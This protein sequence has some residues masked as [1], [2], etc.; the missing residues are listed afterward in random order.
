MSTTDVLR[1]TVNATRAHHVLAELNAA[2][3]W[4]LLTEKINLMEIDEA[5]LH[6]AMNERFSGGEKRRHETLQMAVRAPKHALTS[7]PIINGC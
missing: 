5:L 2:A 6:R 4:R 3:F 7:S 1:T